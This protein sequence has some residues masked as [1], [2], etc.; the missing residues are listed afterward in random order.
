MGRQTK[1]SPASDPRLRPINA[2]GFLPWLNTVSGGARQREREKDMNG[3]PGWS[4]RSLGGP[5]L[6]W[7]DLNCKVHQAPT[8]LGLR[9][10]YADAG[11]RAGGSHAGGHAGGGATSAE[12]V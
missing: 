3:E 7:A 9:P 4:W 5:G 6:H 12:N 11:L 10:R 8:V 1:P 2:G